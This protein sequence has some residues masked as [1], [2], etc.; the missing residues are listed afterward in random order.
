M[1]TTDIEVTAIDSLKQVNA[2]DWD[3]LNQY[4]D[5]FLSHAFLVGLE[6]HDCL[7]PQGWYPIHLIAQ[8]GD[9]LVAAM[10]MY[11][12]DNSYGEFV[13]DWAWADAYERAGG[14]YYPKLVSAIP[15]T[16]ATGNRLLH[17]AD[18]DI[19]TILPAL[20]GAVMKLMEANHASSFHCLF[21]NA[22]QS[23]QLADAGLLTRRA[24]QYHWRNRDYANFD[25]YL[26]AL[27]SKRRKQIRK[28]R[29]DAHSSGLN[30]E[31]LTGDAISARHWHAFHKFYCS[32]FYRKWGEPRLTEEFFNYLS[33]AMPQAPLLVLAANGEE[34]IA[35]SFCMRGGNTLFGRHWGCVE[36]YNHLHFELCYYQNIDFC[37]QE[38]IR[39]FDAGA[40]GEH[41]ITR[42]FEP[43]T[44]W[45]N[46]LIADKGFSSAISSFLKQETSAVKNYIDGLAEHSAF[47]N[48]E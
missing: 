32:T 8:Q 27:K 16:P 43:I 2:D 29:R 7:T 10:P 9:K 30:I 37:I 47:R 4:A 20:M 6:I 11:L 41:K 3:A 34:Y 48:S 23:E 13:F 15:F 25:D 28:E 19:V 12:K 38:K 1:S 31:L 5:P 42:G 21:P 33:T 46:H 40:Q 35:G 18:F 22:L 39:T 45:S 44:T 26:A 24:C 36:H 17:K 14:K